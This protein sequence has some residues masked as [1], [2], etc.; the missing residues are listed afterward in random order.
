MSQ[1]CLHRNDERAQ[2]G[3]D[4]INMIPN[5]K[6]R[7]ISSATRGQVH[8]KQSFSWGTRPRLAPVVVPLSGKRGEITTSG[9]RETSAAAR[10]ET[11]AVV[12]Q[13]REGE[14]GP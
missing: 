5:P 11:S 10:Q 9:Q 4:I 14:D 13:R 2:Q 1:P 3:T 6:L 7:A 8:R 12:A